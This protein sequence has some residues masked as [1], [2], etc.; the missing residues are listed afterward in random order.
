MSIRFTC[1]NC[2]NTV[3]ADDEMAGHLAQCECGQDLTVSVPRPAQETSFS[4]TAQRA[5]VCPFCG[6]TIMA[7]AKK[8]KHCGEFLDPVLI[9][10]RTLPHFIEPSSQLAEETTLRRLHDW[11]RL[12]SIFWIIWGVIQCFTGWLIIAGIWNIVNGIAA[13]KLLPRILAKDATIPNDYEPVAPLVVIGVVNLVLGGVIGVG[14]VIFDFWI[15]DVVLK[16]KHL[17][18]KQ[19]AG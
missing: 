14:F 10:T 4:A 1:P 7:V 19:P 9:R 13:R 16:N 18:D 5:K 11:E 2:N 17:F 12:S 15:R 8:C 3:E 6:E